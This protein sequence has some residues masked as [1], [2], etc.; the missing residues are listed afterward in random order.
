MSGPLVL[1]ALK[2]GVTG[3]RALLKALGLTGLGFG[4]LGTR[5]LAAARER[6]DE[7]PLFVSCLK[8]GDGY[9]AAGVGADGSLRFK[10]PLPDRGHALAFHPTKPHVVVFGRRP[11]YFAAVIDHDSGTALRRIDATPGRHFFGHGTFSPDGRYLF[12]SENDYDAARG[13]LGIRDAADGYRHLGEFPTHGVGPHD[14]RVSR[15][16]NTFVVANGG[17]H[18]HPD[19]GR[20]TLN[21]A[22][23]APSLAYVDMADGRL[24]AA[25]RPP[26][27]LHKLSIRHADFGAD[28]TLAIALQDE[29]DPRRL[30][31][32]V[33]LHDGR[34]E[35]RF[36]EA[37]PG[38]ARRMRR[39]TGAVAFDATGRIAAVSAPRGNL[40]TF[41]DARE[42]RFLGS[43]DSPDGCGVAADGAP[44]GFVMTCG[45]GAVL[46]HDALTGVTAVLRPTASAGYAW[47]NHVL[48]KPALDG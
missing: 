35:L 48:A 20:A 3:R 27:A 10:T 47:D 8:D 2:P 24:R 43:A 38:V 31:P 21:I 4:L 45:T 26:P 40:M 22:T 33:A 32:L 17:I 36:L 37:P 18:T 11:G 34:G 46:R 41:W 42:A 1:P 6:G 16:G 44:G 39:Y 15:D 23:M 7:G 12:T 5:G 19:T 14:V 30:S 25:Y 28:G 29:G 9:A 13:T